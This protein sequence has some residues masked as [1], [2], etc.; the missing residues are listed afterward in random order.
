MADK[1]D[2]AILWFFHAVAGLDKQLC[3]AT[4]GCDDDLGGNTL[5]HE[6]LLH[7]LRASQG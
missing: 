7:H 1:F 4:S 2:A 6:S 3:F 5:A